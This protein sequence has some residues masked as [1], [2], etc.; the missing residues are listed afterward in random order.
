MTENFR[1][2]YFGNGPICTMHQNVQPAVRSVNN[3]ENR[4]AARMSMHNKL[5]LDVAPK[6]TEQVFA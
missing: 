3:R 4:S 2:L 6:F 5:R 1:V